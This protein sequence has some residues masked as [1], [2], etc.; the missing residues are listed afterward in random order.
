MIGSLNINSLSGTFD[1]VLEW[2]EAFDILSIQETKIDRSFPD[3]QFAITDYNMYRR[4]RKK[5]GG[6]IV[7]YVRKSLPSYRLKTKTNEMESI[8]VDFQ[9][10]Q[11]HISLL[12]GYKPPPVNNNI[13]TDEMDAFLDA[14]ISNRPNIICLGDLNCDILHPLENGKEGR[15]WLDICDIY[16]LQNLITA[17]T[18]ISRTKQSCIDIIPT[19]MPE[20]E[21]QSGILEPGLSD[22]KL[23]YTIIAQNA[24]TLPGLKCRVRAKFQIQSGCPMVKQ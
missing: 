16:D 19:N 5:G 6:G 7:V 8:L 4:D 13:F 1:E 11:Q 23:V 3:P 17:P 22:H 9:V 10:S 21:L 18:R 2:I 15:A 24:A 14:A 20:F 12:C